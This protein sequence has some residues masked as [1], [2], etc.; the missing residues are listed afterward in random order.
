MMYSS[1]EQWVHFSRHAY[2]RKTQRGFK[3]SCISHIL[4]FGRKHYQNN[5]I[6]YSIGKKEISK[7]STICPDL[8]QMNGMHL[9]TALNGT[10]I[11]LFRNHNFR[12]LKSK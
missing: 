12:I 8:K 1:I 3:D 9:I 6:Y 4:R 7:Y 11:T 10:V 5:A 2:K